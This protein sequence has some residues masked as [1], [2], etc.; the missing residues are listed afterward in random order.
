M[1]FFLIA[2]TIRWI[3]SSW[4]DLYEEATN[5]AI[6]ADLTVSL[7][8]HWNDGQVSQCEH[9]CCSTDWTWFDGTSCE[10]KGQSLLGIL[11]WERGMYIVHGI[12]SLQIGTPFLG[13]SYSPLGK[14]WARLWFCVTIFDINSDL[15]R[16]QIKKGCLL[17]QKMWRYWQAKQGQ[18]LW[19]LRTTRLVM[20]TKN[21]VAWHGQASSAIL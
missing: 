11:V 10:S 16:M 12:S 7:I 15:D 20:K 1:N 2:H 13:H 6:A 3:F 5:C 8:G 9:Q 19:S 4:W 14:T 18:T 17:S 21:F